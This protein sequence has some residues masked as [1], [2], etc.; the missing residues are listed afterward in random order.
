MSAGSQKILVVDDDS[1]FRVTVS[2]L[3]EQEGFAVSMAPSGEVALGLLAGEP[4]DALIVDQHMR[5]MSGLEFLKR[6]QERWPELPVIL[7][8]AH[9]TVPLAVEA[10]KGGALDFIVKP[11]DRAELISVVKKAMAV[12]ARTV[13]DRL[14]PTL[15]QRAMLGTSRAMREVREL[16][17]KVAPTLATVMILGES[18]TGKELVARALHEHSGRSA[19]PFIKVDCAALPDALL[20]S[21]LFGYERGAFTGALA[22][23]LGRL[24]LAKRGTLFLDEIGDVKA[25]TQ[26][27]LLRALQDRQFERLG[28]IETNRVEARF[29]VA[30]HRNLEEMI[31]AG[32]FR[33]DLFYRLDVVRIGVPPLRARREDIP[34]LASHFCAHFAKQSG[35][36]TLT[37]RPGALELLAEQDWPG[38]VRQLQNLVERLTIVSKH[39]AVEADVVRRE[40]GRRPFEFAT[41]PA[42]ALHG[43][44]LDSHVRR[45]ELAALTQALKEASNNRAL[46]AQLLGVSRRTLYTK[47]AEHGL[48]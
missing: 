44:R 40:L 27:K 36:P 5:G 46:A 24:E 37:L 38:N 9:A 34:V 15:G 20:E 10:I 8:T 21:E 17:R 35:R 43:A 29:V 19:E 4:F 16:I 39:L 47:L 1:A 26:V 18:G 7:L 11:F 12:A 3:L 48:T 45:A 30:T 33:Q 31:A 14:A 42:T 28:A 6:S 23:K 32:T 25:T 22:R 41:S 2:A 13:P